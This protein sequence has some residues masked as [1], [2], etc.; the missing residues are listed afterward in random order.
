MAEE[1]KRGWEKAWEEREQALK[2][3]LETCQIMI[4]KNQIMRDLEL[5]F[6]E[7]ELRSTNIGKTFEQVQR[8][9]HCFHEIT[10]NMAVRKPFLKNA[11]IKIE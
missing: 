3:K 10:E 2:R 11:L 4:E 1:K 6:K 7:V 9:V 5:L 8:G